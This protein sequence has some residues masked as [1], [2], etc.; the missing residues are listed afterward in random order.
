MAIGDCTVQTSRYLLPM[1]TTNEPSKATT[2]KSVYYVLRNYE[3][4][5]TK[6]LYLTRAEAVAAQDDSVCWG[7]HEMEDR[8]AG[9]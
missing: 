1:T 2:A 8:F 4:H 5:E 9:Y 3:T 6:G 7:V